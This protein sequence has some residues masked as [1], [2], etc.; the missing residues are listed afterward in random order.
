M[1]KY[2][3][4]VVDSDCKLLYEWANE[5]LVRANSFN[6]IKID[7]EEHKI[8]FKN[9][10]VSIN[11]YMFIFY[12]NKEPVGQVRLEKV[13]KIGIINYSLDKNHRGKGLSLDMI[14]LLND[15]VN[16][17]HIKIKALVGYVKMENE[18]SQKIFERLHYNKLIENNN[19]KYYKYI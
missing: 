4:R 5:K 10:L 6:S 13:G 14:K 2:L 3:K 17:N 7:F 1:R 8:W 18:A 19:F 9:K 11:S 12:I 15:E 16:I